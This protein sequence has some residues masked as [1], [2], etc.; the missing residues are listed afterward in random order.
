LSLDSRQRCLLSSDASLLISRSSS[1][2]R[3]S[4]SFPG[5]HTHLPLLSDVPHV[6]RIPATTTTPSLLPS[7]VAGSGISQLPGS[8]LVEIATIFTKSLQELGVGRPRHH[9]RMVVQD[10]TSRCYLP[11]IGCRHHPLESLFYPSS[12]CNV[13]SW[14]LVTP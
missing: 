10:L 13:F 1:I 6:P 14:I 8:S 12:T 4:V 9:P 7:F 2:G 11:K 5:T 3:V